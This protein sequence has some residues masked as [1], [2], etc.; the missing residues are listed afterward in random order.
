M[1]IKT[2]RI[3]DKFDSVSLSSSNIVP[4]HWDVHAYFLSTNIYTVIST[5]LKEA[6]YTS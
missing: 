4:V 6:P 5:R 1:Q 3:L 2:Y